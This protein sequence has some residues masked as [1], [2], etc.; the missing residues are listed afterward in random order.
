MKLDPTEGPEIYPGWSLFLVS[1]TCETIGHNQPNVPNLSFEFEWRFYAL[2][3]SKA[4]F[5]MR[6]YSHNLLSPVM[7]ITE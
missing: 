7:M 4:I 2:S 6:T 5:R 1:F 3:A